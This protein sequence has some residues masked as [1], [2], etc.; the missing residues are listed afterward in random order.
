MSTLDAN[1]LIHRSLFVLALALIFATL[2]PSAFAV[3]Q[4]IPGKWAC[5]GQGVFGTASSGVTS[6]SVE[7]MSFTTDAK[8]NL[9]SGIFIITSGGFE[10]QL[11]GQTCRFPLNG[12]GYSVGTGNGIGRLDLFGVVPSTDEDGSFNCGSLFGPLL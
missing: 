3:S 8:G 6:S 11:S 12:G 5:I 2:S 1:C 4:P 10:P 9:T 7:N